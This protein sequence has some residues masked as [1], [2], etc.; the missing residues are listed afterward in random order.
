M[1]CPYINKKTGVIEILI[2]KRR[3]RERERR[4][5]EIIDVAEK[6][7]SLKGFNKTTMDDIAVELELTKPALYRYFKSKED[8]YFAVVVRGVNILDNMMI[9][10]VESKK[11]GIEKI[12]ATGVAFCRFYKKYPEYCRMM[13]YARSTFLECYNGTSFQELAKSD[14]SNLEIMC[15]AIETGKKDGTIRN[16][17]DTFMTAVY[18]VESTIAIMQL[19]EGIDEAM[20][21]MGSDQ[22]FIA[23]SLDLMRHSLENTK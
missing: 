23:H 22:D 21:A 3:K 8:L 1:E 2:S 15:N 5:N 16:D 10:A 18:L 14:K 7:F 13:I 9:G 17:V 6:I 12:H 11:T 20:K 19:S 4:T